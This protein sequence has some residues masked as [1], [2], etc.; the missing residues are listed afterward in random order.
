MRC[1]RHIYTQC[2]EPSL[3]CMI[4]GYEYWL[5]GESSNVQICVESLSMCISTGSNN[6]TTK[7]TLL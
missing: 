7:N 1:L 4:E 3:P 6:I 2:R 5:M